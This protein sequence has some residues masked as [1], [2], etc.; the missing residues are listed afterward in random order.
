MFEELL[1]SASSARRPNTI[2]QI[3][4]RGKHAILISRT[5]S[6][7]LGECDKRCHLSRFVDRRREGKKAE[8]GA[9]A[10]LDSEWMMTSLSLPKRSALGKRR[11]KGHRRSSHGLFLNILH[12]KSRHKTQTEADAQRS[13]TPES[14]ATL[15]QPGFQVN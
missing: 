3:M 8:C 6:T 4:R 11:Q 5:D 12:G 1:V 10:G 7:S 13:L 9:A 15:R 2:K 14:A